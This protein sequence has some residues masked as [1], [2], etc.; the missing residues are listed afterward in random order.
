VV[1]LLLVVAYI[2]WFILVMIQHSTDNQ[3]ITTALVAIPSLL[4]A[5]V[6]IIY[7]LWTKE[8]VKTNQSLFDAQTEPSVI[9]YLC[10]E[11]R[12]VSGG[13]FHI[14]YLVIENI[15]LGI[16]KNVKFSVSPSDLKIG[17]GI[18]NDNP[19]IKKG[20]PVLGPKQRMRINLGVSFVSPFQMTISYQNQ[21]GVPKG[22]QSFDLDPS[23][24]VDS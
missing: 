2:I 14:I 24:V 13:V 12:Q 11:R 18:L 21:I 8:L 5:I 9:A 4:V 15:G 22:S 10:E 1:I 6:T 17:G 7:V 3:Y 23:I 16:A 19:I 20:S